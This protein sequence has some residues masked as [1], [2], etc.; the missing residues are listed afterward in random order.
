MTKK[1]LSMIAGLLLACM[2]AAVFLMFSALFSATDN[3]VDYLMGVNQE[4][5]FAWENGQIWE[6]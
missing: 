5:E 3:L 4:C 1:L 2:V 6:I